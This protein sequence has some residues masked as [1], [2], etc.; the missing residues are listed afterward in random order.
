MLFPKNLSAWAPGFNPILKVTEG[1]TSREFVLI[2]NIVVEGWS[3]SREEATLI[4]TTKGM[5]GT[6]H[7][8]LTFS[9]VQ[10]W[11]IIPKDTFKNYGV[12]D[13]SEEL[14]SIDHIIYDP[15]H[16]EISTDIEFIG[17]GWIV[18]FNAAKVEAV[19][20]PTGDS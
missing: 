5:P 10:Q 2:D 17:L 8:A 7:G 12:H 11:K 3:V 20:R 6:F 18:A 13:S 16:V 14:Q 15:E 1:G 4:F 19:I 9:G